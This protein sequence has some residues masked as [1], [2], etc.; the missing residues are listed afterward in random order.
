MANGVARALDGTVYASSDVGVGIDRIGPD[1]TVTV[2]WAQVLSPNGLAIDRAQKYLYAAQTFQ[3]AQISRIEI[4][5]PSNVETYATPSPD[6]IASG[7]DGMDIDGR[8]RL[9]VAANSGGEIWRVDTDR[10]I[11]ALGTGLTTP[12]AVAYGHSD[13]GFSAGRLFAVGFDGQVS[14]IPGGRVS[15]ADL[16]PDPAGGPAPTLPSTVAPS[17]SVRRRSRPVLADARARP[18]RRRAVGAARHPGAGRRQAGRARA[19]DPP[20]APAD[21][22]APARPQW[23]ACGPG[24]GR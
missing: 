19:Q 16:P 6:G 12:S 10:T 7:P 9:V 14:E 23:S 13:R 18:R 21:R 17:P 15:G 11:C 20:T 2:R 5:N 3:P 4:A 1:G 22:C 8:D 24:S